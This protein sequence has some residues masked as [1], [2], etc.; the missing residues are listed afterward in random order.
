MKR[1]IYLNWLQTEALAGPQQVL[2]HLKSS[3]ALLLSARFLR[4]GGAT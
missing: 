2:H 1:T 4:V 3:C